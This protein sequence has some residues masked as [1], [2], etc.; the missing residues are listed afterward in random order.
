MI[1][2]P[3]QNVAAVDVPGEINQQPTGR[4]EL[5]E[6]PVKIFWR[7]LPPVKSETPGRPGLEIL[8]L[9]F[10]IDD[11]NIFKRDGYMPEQDR[12]RA[13]G[14]CPVPDDQDFI[15]EFHYLPPGYRGLPD[16]RV[17]KSMHTTLFP[18]KKYLFA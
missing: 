3:L 11:R 6:D 10:K 15:P 16:E 9:I 4:E 7:D 8:G 18:D 2:T 17:F 5:R 12:K 1:V 13:L 14:H